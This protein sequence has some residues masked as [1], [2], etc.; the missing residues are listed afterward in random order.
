MRSAGAHDADLAKHLGVS[1][2]AIKKLWTG[3]TQAL[4]AENT[5][6]AAAYLHTDTD[7]LATGEVRPE[8]ASQRVDDDQFPDLP[9][10]E[11]VT[12]YDNLTSQQRRMVLRFMSGFGMLPAEQQEEIEA[13]RKRLEMDLDSAKSAGYKDI[14]PKRPTQSGGRGKRR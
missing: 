3:A 4:S 9:T 8:S 7:L 14:S 6:K 13:W 12:I 5:S 2:Q 1:I 11:F 10:E